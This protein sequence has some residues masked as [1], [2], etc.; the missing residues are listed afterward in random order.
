MEQDREPTQGLIIPSLTL[1]AALRQPT[2]YGK[3]V[4]DVRILVFGSADPG[5][6]S[7]VGMLLEDNED[8]V[9]VM[10][11][12][13]THN[14]H[15]V[16]ASTDWA[17]HRDAHGLEKFEPTHNVEI[18]DIS[19]HASADE[20][21]NAIAHILAIIHEPFQDLLDVID[22]ACPPSALLSSLISSSS[23]PLYTALV[24]SPSSV[25]S[26]YRAII[27]GLGAHIPVVL[28][29]STGLPRARLPI[30][31]FRPSSAHALRTGIFRSPETLNLLRS[32][33]ADRFLRW[34]EIERAACTVHESRSNAR[35]QQG[36]AWDKAAWET[37]WD[38][39]LSRD[40]AR[41][42]RENTTTSP[43]PSQPHT[44]N[45]PC[46]PPILDPFHIPS[47]V[48]CSLALL[49]PLKDG[50]A[51]MNLSGKRLGIVLAGTLCAGVGIGLALRAGY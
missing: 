43:P 27:D 21:D 25:S 22:P 26:R 36:V 17:E 7:V 41:R 47:L 6:S 39:T 29:P 46:T 28:L 45:A 42:L 40:V 10:P 4:G 49:T 12:E 34:R 31:A 11:S 32:E 19:K 38:A 48:M 33:A 9:D 18:I 37:E 13:V 35:T 30:S 15:V 8:V 16:R 44:R 23:S 1:P 5:A 24:V 20:A 14:G 2:T 50:I 51:Q 3:T